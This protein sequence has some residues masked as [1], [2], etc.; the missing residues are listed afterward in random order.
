MGQTSNS[1][2]V[3]SRRAAVLAGGSAPL[4]FGILGSKRAMAETITIRIGSD[5]T[6]ADEHTV[7]A[8][9]MKEHLEAKTDGRMKVTIFPSGQLGS[10]EVM[11]NAIKAGTLDIVLSDLGVL[12]LGV[13]EVSVFN[14]PFLFKDIPH[15]I[16]AA[17]GSVGAK[18]K[19][20]IE[21]AYACEVHGWGNDGLRNIWNGKRPIKSPDD[22]VGLKIRVQANPIH[23]E[24][25]TALGA[26]P[27]V[28]SFPELY[29]ALQ[30]GVVDGAD[31]SVPDIISEKFYQVTKYLTVTAHTSSMDILLTSSKFMSRLS[32]A[33]QDLVREAG[34]A[35]A[36]SEVDATIEGDRKGLEALKAKGMQLTT[37]VD[38]EPFKAKMRPVYDIAAKTVGQSLIDEARTIT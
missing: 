34:A 8:I 1:R 15:A 4:V 14:L 28:V 37:D 20:K 22:L 31:N 21:S 12:S 33:D 5:S 16:R 24:T 9:K 30:T 3:L 18:L 17:K 26:L 2:M 27:T 25:Y 19:P 35:S 23:K 11:V 13:P 36:D 7:S 32:P 38:L 6:M 29:N 10:N